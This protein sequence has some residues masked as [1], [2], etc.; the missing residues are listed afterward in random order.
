MF[1][2]YP[3]ATPFLEYFATEPQVRLELWKLLSGNA[4]FIISFE[5]LRFA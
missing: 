1:Q 4:I 3:I 2:G 5:A